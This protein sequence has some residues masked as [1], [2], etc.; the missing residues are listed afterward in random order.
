M[1]PLRYNIRSL[2]VRKLTTFATA[3]GIALVVFV[4]AGAL[5]LDEGINRAVESAARTDNVVILRK[6]S[7]NELSSGFPQANLALLATPPQVMKGE[8]SVI[9]E[10]VAVMTAERSDGSGA[11]SNLLIRGMPE[12]GY[13]F[14]SEAKLVS[15]SW[16]KPGT[17]EVVIGRAIT[18]RFLDPSSNK[19][20]DRGGSF[21]VKR[22][23]PLQV[24]GVFEAAGSTFEAEVWGDLDVIRK[25]LGRE[26]GLSS[27]RVR[28]NSADDFDAYRQAVESNPQLEVK[29]QREPDYLASQS[30]MVSNMLSK[31]GIMIAILFSL[32]AMI[33]AAITMNAAVANRTREI[34]TLR[35]LGFGKLGIMVGFLFEA[36]VLTAIGA[37]IGCLLVLVLTQVRFAMINF[38]TFSEIVITFAASPSVVISS[39]IFSTV[40]GLLGGLIPAIRAARISP[41][42]AMRA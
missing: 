37:V 17:N 4:F 32:A 14:R 19:V 13:A 8:G 10:V 16:P 9:G 36:I 11:I 39:L 29:A 20:I 25:H 30:E 12:K 24:V 1:V 26:G 22:N 34:G 33:G 18:G 35:A 23:R 15:G 28:L 21:D 40:M 27:A 31:L 41:V 42:E 5:M 6:G 2:F 3:F 38:Q 7:E